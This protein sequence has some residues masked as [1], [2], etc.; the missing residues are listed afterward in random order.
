MA[1]PNKCIDCGTDVTTGIRCKPCNGKHI[2]LTA[3]ID[4][5]IND[6]AL[7]AMVDKEG[8]SAARL[9]TRLGISRSG[10]DRRIRG[11]RKRQQLLRALDIK[12]GTVHKTRPLMTA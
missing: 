7:L 9:G 12:Q 1:D 4:M 11:A 10:A 6:V 2:K 8:L 3:A 5:D